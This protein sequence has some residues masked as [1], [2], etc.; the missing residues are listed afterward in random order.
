MRK[1]E[2]L[3]I[4][5]GIVSMLTFIPQQ[6]KQMLDRF[7]E[8]SIFGIE[9]HGLD[10]DAVSPESLFAIRRTIDKWSGGQ[11]GDKKT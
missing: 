4:E 1:L 9:H 6:T 8:G 10:N 3:K 11:D 5:R 7:Y 2:K